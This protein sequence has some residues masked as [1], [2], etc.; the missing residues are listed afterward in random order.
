MGVTP[1]FGENS[2]GDNS[3]LKIRIGRR[4][5][6]QDAACNPPQDARCPIGPC[7]G[8]EG[9]KDHAGQAFL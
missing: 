5:H 1:A 8:A 6:L 3:H 2:P 4:E 7:P 9:F